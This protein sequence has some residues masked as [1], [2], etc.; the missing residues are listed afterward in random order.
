MSREGKAPQVGEMVRI[1]RKHPRGKEL[2][3][4]TDATLRALALDRS[5]PEDVR[6]LAAVLARMSAGQR[7]LLAL[8]AR[9]P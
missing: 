6:M 4:C 1:V 2:I 7:Q 8:K 5:K 9:L 3:A